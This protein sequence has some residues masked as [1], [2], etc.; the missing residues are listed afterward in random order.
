M[1]LN[2]LDNPIKHWSNGSRWEMV[3]CMSKQI[4]KQTQTTIVGENFL[5]LNV[6]EVIIID[7]QSWI[8]VHAYVMHAWKRNH[9]LLTLHCVVEGGNAYNLI[10]IIVQTLM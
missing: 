9:I 4:L 1:Q 7:N 2:V 8:S 5:F 10:I 3:D 6:D